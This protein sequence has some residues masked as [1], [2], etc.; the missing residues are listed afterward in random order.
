ML[1]ALAVMAATYF[2]TITIDSLPLLLISRI[3]LAAL[4]YF[5]VM[6]AA[7]VKILDECI[8]YFSKK[9]C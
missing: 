5:A 6:K 7:R 2:L 4:L 8:R 9:T 3:V 1:A